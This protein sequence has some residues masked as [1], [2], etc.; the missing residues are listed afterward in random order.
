MLSLLTYML[1]NRNELKYNY[2][3]VF[4]SLFKF[5][6]VIYFHGG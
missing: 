6:Q 5:Q 4:F 1:Y 2:V 3:S